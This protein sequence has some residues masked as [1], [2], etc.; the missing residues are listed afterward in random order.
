MRSVVREE[1]NGPRPFFW[2]EIQFGGLDGAGGSGVVH[3]LYAVRKG[4]AAKRGESGTSER[5]RVGGEEGR[6]CR[7]N[8]PARPAHGGR[9]VVRGRR[10]REWTRDTMED[11]SRSPPLLSWFCL[12]FLLFRTPDPDALVSDYVLKRWKRD[13]EVERLQSNNI[14]LIFL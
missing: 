2:G 7:A 8:P 12:I 14:I 6:K 5:G 9:D 1:E 11:D 4:T 13:C 3:I 10:T